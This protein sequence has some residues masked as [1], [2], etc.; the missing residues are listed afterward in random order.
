MTKNYFAQKAL[1]F[2]SF[3]FFQ[4]TIFSQDC[5]VLKESLKG[6]Y[7]GDCKKGKASGKGKA[8]GT[9]SY[10]GEFRSGLPD[11][12]GT[13]TWK[14]GDVYTGHFIKGMMDG[15]GQ[16]VFKRSGAP[17]SIVGGYWKK[18]VYI[19]RYEHPYKVFSKS[20]GI[21]EID[22]EYKKDNNNRL[23]FNVS[24]T[25]AGAASFQRSSL[26]VKVDDIVMFEGSIGRT[27]ITNSSP[28]KMQSTVYDVVF[29][30]R[31]KVVLGED[32]FEVEF[33]EPGTY[34]INISI[35]R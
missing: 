5:S 23:I 11:G 28:K 21:G 33:L 34:T 15:K 20:S 2:I 16:F 35:N 31:M 32:N 10:E 19:G 9:D 26:S 22:F 4:G 24:N 25:S 30:A 3:L 1:L 8:V 12:D 29:P 14:N 18:D 27:D 13:Y 7:T 17:D 6:S